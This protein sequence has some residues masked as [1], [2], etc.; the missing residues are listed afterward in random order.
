[1]DLSKCRAAFAL[2]RELICA[3]QSH[4]RATF[5][6]FNTGATGASRYGGS[7][8]NTI[9]SPSKIRKL[10]NS[11]LSPTPSP[12][13]HHSLTL[14]K[15]PML[16]LGILFCIPGSDRLSYTPDACI[17]DGH[18]QM[19]V[20]GPN[21]NPNPNSGH[22]QMVVR[23]PNFNPNPNPNSGHTQMVVRGSNF[24]PNPTLIGVILR[25]WLG[26]W[27]PLKLQSQMK[28]I[29]DKIKTQL[30]G[31]ST[32]R[33]ILMGEQYKGKGRRTG[34]EERGRGHLLRYH[35]LPERG[36]GHLLRYHTLPERGRG[37][38]LR[39][40]TLPESLGLPSRRSVVML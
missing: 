7:A 19:V 38:L 3:A 29:A 39:Y 9:T 13:F 16:S 15:L 24:N 32:M 2:P 40:H 10:P 5:G 27:L 12:S 22:A 37:H 14:I 28:Q 6:R 4:V 20:R 8:L 26:S 34:E 33:G 25:W 17:S 21:F 35:T 11:P 23:G 18:T 31:R 1:M 30:Q 36:R